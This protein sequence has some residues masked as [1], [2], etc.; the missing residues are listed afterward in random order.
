MVK[1]G[2]APPCKRPSRLDTHPEGVKLN[3]TPVKPPHGLL[4]PS[5]P[6]S[7][8]GA[9][10]TQTLVFTGIVETCVPVIAFDRRGDGGRLRL[11]APDRDDWRPGEGQ[12]I[13]VCGACLTVAAL[14]EGGRELVFDL[15]AET[16]ERT[17]FDALVRERPVNLERP[18]KLG[19]R[20]DGHLV[21]GHVDGGATIVSISDSGDGGR[22][23]TFEVDVGLERYLIE[24]GSITL[25]G[26]SLTVCDPR[27]RCFDVAIIPLTLEL[28]NLGR[29]QPGQRVNVEA[30][31]LGKW[32]EQLMP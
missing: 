11:R 22:L 16:L 31:M 30:D 7:G 17:W 9:E 23:F 12:S 15:S 20:L 26:I 21:A 28:T 32:I 19:D 24:K 18:L 10:S 29:A 3:R 14:E 27:E 8:P 1:S 2:K 25:D 5:L 6:G 4:S 13:A